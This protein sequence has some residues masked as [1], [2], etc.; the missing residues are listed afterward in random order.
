[1]KVLSLF[2][3]GA[4]AYA[5]LIRA[6]FNPRNIQ[7]CASEIDQYAIAVSKSLTASPNL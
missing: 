4:M 7:Y 1:M 3:G 2:D 5:S 6:G